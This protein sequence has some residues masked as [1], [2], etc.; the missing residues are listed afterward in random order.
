MRSQWSPYYQ[1]NKRVIDFAFK[2]LFRIAGFLAASMVVIIFVFIF[3]KGISVFF[4]EN[5][6]SFIE[7]ITGRV[8]R[9][10]LG[11]YGV[12]FILV[13]TLLTAFFAVVLAF[14]V[15]V[16]T[17]L[18]IGKIAPKPIS[19]FLKTVIELLAAIPSIIYGVF[20]SGVIVKW[21]DWLAV[22][23]FNQ[24]TYGG[25]SNLA[26]ILLLA[27][28]IL[29]TM[30]MLSLTAIEAVDHNLELGSLALG[31]TQTQTNF[32]IVLQSA[33]SGIFAGL[34]LG[35]ARAFGEA[36]AVSLVAGNKMYG[37][38]FNPFDMTRT[39]TS[40]MLLGMNETSGIDYD[41]RFSVGI[42]LLIVILISNIAINL[43]KKKVGN[44]A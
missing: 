24:S 23:I 10:D 12:F 32:K 44:H 9:A 38:S 28:M 15:S 22:N 39:L 13:N 36:T 11:Q 2:S 42:V 1:K 26:V 27:L 7:F 4:G 33:K 6:I 16:L 35:L 21:V 20:A 8:W 37:P 30:T 34:I 3:K 31:A 29:P 40:T 41:I 17:A 14:P 43:V 19:H 18:F 25:R 5:S